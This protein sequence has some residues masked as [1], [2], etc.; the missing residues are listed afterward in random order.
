[1]LIL[2]RIITILAHG[3]YIAFRHTFTYRLVFRQCIYTDY[4][5]IELTLRFSVSSLLL[6]F[7]LFY[8][9]YFSLT[10]FSRASALL[11]H[12]IFIYGI[13]YEIYSIMDN[14]CICIEYIYGTS[15]HPRPGRSPPAYFRRTL[16]QICFVV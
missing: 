5:C 13:V 15:F 6:I 12:F 7:P 9:V 14:I 16:K 3:S 4:T 11:V 10:S 2:L 1:M 8:I